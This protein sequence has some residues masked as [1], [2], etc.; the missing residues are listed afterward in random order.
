[1]TWEYTL[2]QEKIESECLEI[3]TKHAKEKEKRKNDINQSTW[4]SR[5]SVH[6]DSIYSTTDKS[7]QQTLVDTDEGFEQL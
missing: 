2:T 1:M 5:V 7:K 3:P 6:N 4:Q